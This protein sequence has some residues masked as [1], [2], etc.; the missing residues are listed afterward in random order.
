MHK[1]YPKSFACE[2]P[3]AYCSQSR[4]V[5]FSSTQ[6]AFRWTEPCQTR[7]HPTSWR[8]AYRCWRS[9]TSAFLSIK[10]PFNPDFVRVLYQRADGMADHQ[11]QKLDD[12][13]CAA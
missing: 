3:K 4:T 5:S 6:K 1:W 8:Y 13:S 11:P 7:R 9:K 2:S 12:P 10:V